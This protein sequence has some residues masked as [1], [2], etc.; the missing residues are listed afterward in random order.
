MNN[1]NFQSQTARWRFWLPL[2]LQLGLILLI[3]AQASWTRAFGT[4]VILQTAP[5][6][7]YDL[8]RG[9]YVTLNYNISQ[10]QTLSTLDGWENWIAEQATPTDLSGPLPQQVTFYLTLQAPAETNTQPPQPWQPIAIS[11]DRPTQ[12]R[13]NQVV[14]K[15]IA[16][17]PPSA[18]P[19]SRWLYGLERYYIP[20]D[21]RQDINDRIQTAQAEQPEQFLVEV[22]VNRQGEAVPTQIWIQ[23]QAY[24]F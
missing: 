14:L 20:E 16:T 10:Q 23:G 9:Y 3:P 17:P 21:Q 1:S 8:F 18:G 13:A 24:R 2:V 19:R 4:S 11:G 12:L 6:D 5:V 22:S 15:G 7:P